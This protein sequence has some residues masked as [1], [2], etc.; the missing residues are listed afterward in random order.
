MS[1]ETYFYFRKKVFRRAVFVVFFAFALL[2]ALLFMLGL[3]LGKQTKPLQGKVILTPKPPF[4]SENSSQ[5]KKPLGK[6]DWML[7]LVNRDYPIVQDYSVKLTTL[8]GGYQVDERIVSALSQM[9]TDMRAQGLSP[10]ACSGY[11]S[12]EKQQDLFEKS[13]QRRLNSGMAYD[14]AYAQTE[15]YVAKPGFSEHHLGLAVDIV[16]VA[17][18][19]LETEEQVLTPE[20]VWLQ[21]N[22][23]EYGFILRYPKDKESV[24]G[25]LYEPWHFRYVGK[26]AAREMKE[27]GKTLEEYLGL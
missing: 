18:Q 27:S 22:C 25:Y 23:F 4:T 9:F 26:E 6:E 19:N 17:N 5:G 15:K 8:S 3:A 10:L 1:R 7:T 2:S 20:N 13:M 14:E 12:K 11:R 16:S 24:T 21:S